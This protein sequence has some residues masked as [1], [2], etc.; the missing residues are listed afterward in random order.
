MFLKFLL[1]AVVL[2]FV[3]AFKNDE[4]CGVVEP[5]TDND[6]IERNEFPWS[7]AIFQ[8]LNSTNTKLICSGTLIT[9][10]KVIIAA[11]CIHNKYSE[12]LPTSDFVLK[13]GIQSISEEPG[14][15]TVKPSNITI[16]PDWDI[17]SSSYDADIAVIELP[18]EITISKS[19][20]PICLWDQDEEAPEF[21]EGVVKSW[22]LRSNADILK[23]LKLP[24]VTKQQ[25]FA[26]K[27]VFEKLSSRRTFCAGVKNGAAPCLDDSGSGLFFEFKG[28]SHLGGIVSASVLI[29]TFDCNTNSYA[30]FTD[31]IQFMPWIIENKVTEGKCFGNL[32]CDT[33]KSCH[34]SKCID[35]CDAGPCGENADCFVINHRPICACSKRKTG[36]P[37]IQCLNLESNL[38]ILFKYNHLPIFI[39]LV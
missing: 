33:K 39:K 36:D 21:K 25:C 32:D 8:V 11:H 12:I 24:V 7:V 27:P 26:D 18:N 22:G 2:K 20:R 3:S 6:Q 29:N 19:I 28:R 38:L 31:V 30:I 10:K 14:T 4:H 13:F 9:S 34:L 35:P 23:T 37:F 16:H 17:N 1:I 15:E 5:N